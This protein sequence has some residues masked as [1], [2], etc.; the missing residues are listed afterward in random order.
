MHGRILP[1][2]L[3]SC[4]DVQMA[5]IPVGRVANRWPEPQTA[6]QCQANCPPVPSK[7]PASPTQTALWGLH[8]TLLKYPSFYPQM[9]DVNGTTCRAQD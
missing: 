7:L 6:R 4:N 9:T 8:F 3:P 5:Q 1:A 2:V